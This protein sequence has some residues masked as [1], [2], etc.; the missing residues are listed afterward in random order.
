VAFQDEADMA[1][2]ALCVWREARGES[3]EGKIAVA[4]SI[5]NRLASP[6]WG[7]S[8][9]T[10]LFQRLQY[11]SLTHA[12]DPQLSVWPK[13]S[14]P[15]WQECLEVASGVLEEQIPSNVEKADSYHDISIQPPNWASTSSFVKQIGRIRFYR[16]GK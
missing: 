11:S 15:S 7:N 16:V 12:S 3:R 8:I 10:V 14:D 6:S 13:D 9:M 1:F 5:M 4:H 2:L